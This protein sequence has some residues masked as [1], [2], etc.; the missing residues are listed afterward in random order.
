MSPGA[1]SAFGPTPG[2]LKITQRASARTAVT[3]MGMASE[4]Q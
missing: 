2:T 1:S 4:S 3:G